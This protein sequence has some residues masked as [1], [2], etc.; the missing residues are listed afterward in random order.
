MKNAV[1]FAGRQMGVEKCL[2]LLYCE[3]MGNNRSTLEFRGLGLLQK[4]RRSLVIIDPHWNLELYVTCIA[5]LH[6]I[7]IIDPH[8]NLEAKDS[9][10]DQNQLAVIIDPHW[11]LELC[12]VVST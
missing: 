12:A 3:C 10:V 5:A 1:I 4:E 8:W 9:P 6:S 11:N 2:F 7:V